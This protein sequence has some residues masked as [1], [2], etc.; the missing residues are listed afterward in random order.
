MHRKVNDTRLLAD[1]RYITLQLGE[2]DSRCAQQGEGH[3]ALR[4]RQVHH[5]LQL[6]EGDSRCAQEGE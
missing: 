3:Q 1:V 5:T 2:G 6:G 4:R